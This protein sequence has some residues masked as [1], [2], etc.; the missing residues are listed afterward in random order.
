MKFGR[1]VSIVRLR[2]KGHGVFLLYV[3]KIFN[4]LYLII[5]FMFHFNNSI[6]SVV[7]FAGSKHSVQIAFERVNASF[8]AVE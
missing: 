6:N 4:Y 3:V 5:S 8:K 7:L 1:S 2:T